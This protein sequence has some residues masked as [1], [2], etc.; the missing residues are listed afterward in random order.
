MERQGQVID[1]PQADEARC[2]AS[3]APYPRYRIGTCQE[4]VKT[5]PSVH[6]TTVEPAPGFARDRTGSIRGAVLMR[7]MEL[8]EAGFNRL[9]HFLVEEEASARL[10]Q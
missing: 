7:V 1:F 3:T 4:N 2:R 9:S 10:A 8:D 6:D 5:L